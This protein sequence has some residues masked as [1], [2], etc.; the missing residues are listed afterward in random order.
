M[1]TPSPTAKRMANIPIADVA[2]IE[3]RSCFLDPA[4]STD[5]CFMFSPSYDEWFGSR[6]KRFNYQGLTVSG[7][8]SILTALATGRA[9]LLLRTLPTVPVVLD[10]VVDLALG[11]SAFAGAAGTGAGAATGVSSFCPETL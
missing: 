3:P 1:S 10:C 4:C 8:K 5:L 11:S 7:F 9:G 2:R 6:K